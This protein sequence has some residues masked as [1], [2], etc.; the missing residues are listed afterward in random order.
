MVRTL[1]WGCGCA[2]LWCDIDL[3]SDLAVVT[4]T[5]K[6]FSRLFLKKP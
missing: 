6:L 2:L 1:V 3:A 5:F 4:L